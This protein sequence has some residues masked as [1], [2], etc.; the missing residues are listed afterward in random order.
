MKVT[1]GDFN[2]GSVRR[3]LD[4]KFPSVMKK[5]RATNFMFRDKAKFDI[6]NPVIGTLYQ[7]LLTNK[8]KKKKKN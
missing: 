2:D 6:Q 7:Q 5:P 8:Q 1:D 3:A 4:T